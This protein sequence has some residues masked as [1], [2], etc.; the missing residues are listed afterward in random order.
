MLHYI[1]RRTLLMIPTLILISM[2]SFVIIQLPP[3]D[4][5]TSQIAELEAQ[6]EIGSAGARQ[7]I[8]ML[9]DRYGLNDPLYLRYG[10]WVWGIITRLD[11]GDSFYYEMSVRQVFEERLGLTLLLTLSTLAFSWI[12]AIPLGVYSAVR[13][14]SLGDY[15]L[16]FFGFL[17]LA[18]PNF[19]IA[20]VIMYIQMRVFHSPSVGG[21][22]SAEY[23]GA[24]W[25]VRKV[26]DL[27]SHLWI[28][29]LVIGTAGTATVLRIMRGNLLDI[30]DQPHIQAARA[31]GLNEWFVI[32]KY[33]VRLALN[34]LVSRLGLQL[35][36]LLSGAVVTSVVL[37]LPTAGPVFLT[38]LMTQDMYLAGA[39]L[40]LS[41]AFLLTGNLLADI[42]LA[43]LDP[44]IRYD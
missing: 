42:A 31:K 33:A 35:P 38:S 39:F 22:F 34:P 8:E 3:G 7:Q 21:L 16:T 9:R 29:V 40:L 30:L 28:P 1:I 44:R 11:F 24:P 13:Q 36:N 20:L 19:L 23:I 25:S 10:R 2:I 26:L 41:G 15:T 17:G 18:T 6:G 4:I 37:G 43:L 14:Y 27:L 32:F 12:I 5:L